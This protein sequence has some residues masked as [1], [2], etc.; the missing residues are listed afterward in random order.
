M[1]GAEEGFCNYLIRSV[2]TSLPDVYKASGRKVDSL[3]D[4]LGAF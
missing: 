4:G 1:N 3:G 2:G